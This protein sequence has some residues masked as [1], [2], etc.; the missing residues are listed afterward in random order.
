MT[1]RVTCDAEALMR[2]AHYTAHEYLMH[3]V[4]DINK[5]LGEGYA[6]KHPELLGAYMRTAALD[7][8]AAQINV[9]GHA[10]ADAIDRLANKEDE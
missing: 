9:A 1:D 2:Q 4:S 5:W 10:I 8:L 3:G 7:F 6:E